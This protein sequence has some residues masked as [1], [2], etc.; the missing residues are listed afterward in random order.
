MRKTEEKKMKG[1]NMF[2]IPQN[3]QENSGIVVFIFT[4]P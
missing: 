4:M 1:W 2:I 3:A